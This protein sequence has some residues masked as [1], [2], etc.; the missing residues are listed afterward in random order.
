MPHGT[1]W[2]TK[3]PPKHPE[4]SLSPDVGSILMHLVKQGE[5]DGSGATSDVFYG[6]Q[7]VGRHCGVLGE[8][9][10]QRRNQKHCVGP[11]L[12]QDLQEHPRVKRR[13][14]DLGRPVAEPV[15]HD[16]VELRRSHISA[17][18]IPVGHDDIKAFIIPRRCGRVGGGA[19]WWHCPP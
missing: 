3:F 4:Q 10:D 17:S 13:H 7:V 11:V 18:I 6:G 8:K 15:G 14:D 2:R 19:G 12:R 16:D 1:C 5:S 9:L